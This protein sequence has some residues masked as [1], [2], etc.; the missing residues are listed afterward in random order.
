MCTL[1]DPILALL[2]PAESG[3]TSA[4]G[5][6]PGCIAHILLGLGVAVT[7]GII[8]WP[9]LVLLWCRGILLWGHIGV[10]LLLGGIPLLALRGRYIAGLVGLGMG[11]QLLARGVLV[12]R[13]I[14]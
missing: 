7:R 9:L 6:C 4:L 2:F 3:I 14:V 1:R 12:G 8:G 5:W 10:V 13:R 11:I